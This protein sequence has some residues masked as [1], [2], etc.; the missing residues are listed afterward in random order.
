MG[1]VNRAGLSL[2]SL[3]CGEIKK[4]LGLGLAPVGKW[5]PNKYDEFV[6]WYQEI[7]HQFKSCTFCRAS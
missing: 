1:I 4:L 3:E 6:N 7:F 5:Y 2:A